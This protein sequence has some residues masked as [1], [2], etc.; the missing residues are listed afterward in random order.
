MRTEVGGIVH[1]FL[2]PLEV[3]WGMSSALNTS[4]LPLPLFGLALAR[5][6]ASEEE[7]HFWR[8]LC[9]GD[10]QPPFQMRGPLSDHLVSPS[11]LPHPLTSVSLTWSLKICGYHFYNFLVTPEEMRA[12]VLL[13]LFFP[14]TCPAETKGS[15]KPP[16][17]RNVEAK[18]S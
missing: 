6:V 16:A 13:L 10:A 4:R 3:G 9:P 5:W 14:S 11:V 8:E 7:R 1:S 17:F 12:G 18:S 15:S 2:T